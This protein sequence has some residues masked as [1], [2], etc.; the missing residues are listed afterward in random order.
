MENRQ[1]MR[2]QST[3]DESTQMLLGS[4]ELAVSANTNNTESSSEDTEF[5]SDEV[6]LDST[7]E[8]ENENLALGCEEDTRDEELTCDVDLAIDI[9]LEAIADKVTEE[10]PTEEEIYMDLGPNERLGRYL[11]MK[12]ES[13]KM[14]IDEIA[15][16]TKIPKMSLQALEQGKFDSLPGDVFVRGFL[17]S[18]A[19]CLKIDGNDVIRRYAECGLC[20]APVSS[21]M[22]DSLLSPH[23]RKPRS[24]TSNE[25]TE[26]VKAKRSEAKKQ[27]KAEAKS[28]KISASKATKKVVKKVLKDA[29]DLAKLPKSEEVAKTSHKIEVVNATQDAVDASP[30]LVEEKRVR[31][32]IPPALDYGEDMSSRGPLTLGVIILVIVATLTMSYLLRRP[33]TSTEGFT[34]APDTSAPMLEQ[35]NAVQPFQIG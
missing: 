7:E 6:L 16:T 24:F 31:I 5:L 13:M 11:S 12:R 18:F 30:A 3:L 1:N 32:F 2:F 10:E 23:S 26:E 14:S 25:N 28:E 8:E 15:R 34:M 33:G 9:E 4:D 29:F 17:R 35:G 19:R 21:E 20:P 27:G 22:A